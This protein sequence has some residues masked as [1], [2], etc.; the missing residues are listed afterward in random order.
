MSGSVKIN[1][2]GIIYLCTVVCNFSY[3]QITI[4]KN[5]DLEL[6]EKDSIKSLKL[7]KSLN[8]FLTEAQ[9]GSFS[10]KYVDSSHQK[11]YEFFFNKLL[12]FGKNSPDRIFNNPIVIKSYSVKDEGEIYFMT[13]SLSGSENGQPFIYRIV[14]IKAVPYKDHY[15][16][17]S[18]FEERT[19]NFKSEKY[20]SLTYYY[21][22][23]LNNQKAVEFSELKNELSALT[24]TEITPLDYYKFESIDELLKSYGLIYSA[25]NCN[26]LCYDL[27]F[28]DSEGEMYLTG[29][30]NENY[31]FGY[32]GDYLYYNLPNQDEIYSPFV[33]G[34]ST[35]YGG[36]GLSYDTLEELKEQ[37]RD[38]IER[39]PTIDFLEEFKK[40]RKS[41]VS[42]HFS[43]FV[44]SAFIC[45]EVLNKK[46]FDG[47]LKLI[48]SGKDG[49]FF[50]ENLKTT[51]DVDEN[52]FHQTILKLING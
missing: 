43:Y 47:V 18:P 36:Y 40:G 31:I 4:E 30:D 17:Y 8:S 19:A 24:K 21:S 42:R 38:E 32:V 23:S 13:F 25:N 10:N 33:Y 1:I 20:N 16:F 45:E 48:Y 12:G 29:T 7:E 27:G 3:G 11:K 26:F 9:N 50:F 37:F 49:E 5:F 34:I 28:T 2:I 14:E 22:G 52:N 35:Y 39:N 41:S 6:V 51:I 15:R 46:G 44:M